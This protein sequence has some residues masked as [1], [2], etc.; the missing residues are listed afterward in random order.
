MTDPPTKTPFETKDYRISRHGALNTAVQIVTLQRATVTSYP[1]SD[2]GH[3][4]ALS[5]DLIEW[6]D[7]V[8][9][10]VETPRP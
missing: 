7:W 9:A 4:L 3:H 10:Y 8:L 5:E 6:A 1:K 2:P